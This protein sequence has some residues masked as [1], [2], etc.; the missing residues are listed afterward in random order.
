MAQETLVLKLAPGEHA[1]LRRRLAAEDFEFRTVPHAK[2]SVKGPQIVATLYQS[3]KLVIQGADPALFAARFVPGAVRPAAPPAREE[4]SEATRIGSDECGKGD[5]FG[6]LVVAAVRLDPATARALA[7]GEVAD[8]KQL[9]DATALRL[10]AAL[11]GRVPYSV[12]RLDPPD[13]NR[14][15]AAAGKGRLNDLLADLHAR[16]IRAL[17]EPGVHVLID[18]FANERLMRERL[19]DLDLELEQR[20]RAERFI[21]VAAA[22]V[23]A[24]EEFLRALAALSEEHAVDLHKGA[25]APVDRAGAG[26][27]RLH[28]VEKLGAVAKLHFKNTAKIRARV[29]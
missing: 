20:T 7:G 4:L 8:S 10:G 23:I 3:G 12:A 27:V 24:R 22:S 28:G 15:Y 19:A 16:A 1:T 5:Y 13:Y 21:A 6:P 14:A 11:R 18:K 2:F 9:D 25:G 17:H 29:G 26:F